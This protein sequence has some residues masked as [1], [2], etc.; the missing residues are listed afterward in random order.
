MIHKVIKYLFICLLFVAPASLF[1]QELSEEEMNREKKFR[2]SI[3]KMVENYEN[4]LKLEDWQVFYVDSILTHDFTALTEELQQMNKAKVENPDLYQMSQDK[5]ME[6][7]YNAFRKVL[8]DKQWA[9]YL[10]NG[11]SKDKKGRDKRAAN[12][13]SK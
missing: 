9:K 11:A 6:Q 4:D 8:D 5:W 1:A 2:E 12:R 7:M 3:D 13:N 10:K